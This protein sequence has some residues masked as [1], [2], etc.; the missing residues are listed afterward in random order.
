MQEAPDLS[1][2]SELVVEDEYLIALEVEITL[3]NAGCV[4]VGPFANVQAAL[5][6]LKVEKVDLALL[7]VNLAGELVFPMAYFLE[8]GGTP[9]LF[10]TG[11]GQT[12]LPSNRPS[13]EA[14]PKPFQPDELTERLAQKVRN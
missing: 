14:C 12:I 5:E 2:G 8:G 3:L 6:A 7:D 4:V 11:H 1:P 13:W 9:F 10:V